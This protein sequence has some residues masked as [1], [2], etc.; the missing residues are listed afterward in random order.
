[1][2]ELITTDILGYRNF[3]RLEQAFFYLIE[4]RI[5]PHLRKSIT[6]FRKPVEVSSTG[7][8]YTSLQYQ[9]WVGRTTIYKIFPQVCK[10]IL[11]EFQQEY[12]VCSTN[13][14]DWKKIEESLKK[15]ES[16]PCNWCT[17]W[18]THCCKEAQEVWQ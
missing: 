1:M 12:L 5:T 2:D 9:W 11:K 3:T 18:K 16:P 14:E 4:E 10:A 8:S 15:M 13:P 17:R 7:E 6:N